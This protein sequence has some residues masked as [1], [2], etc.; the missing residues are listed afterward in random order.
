M[1]LSLPWETDTQFII[2]F[3]YL[4]WKPNLIHKI[5]LLD[6]TQR[7]SS[8]QPQALSNINFNIIL[9]R[10]PISSPTSSPSDF[11]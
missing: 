4:V 6:P 9:T 10:V 5:L 2:K 1:K 8:L 3:T 11:D 7:Q